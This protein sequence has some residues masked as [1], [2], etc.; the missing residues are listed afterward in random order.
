MTFRLKKLLPNPDIT[1]VTTA[2]AALQLLLPTGLPPP[3][4]F[5]IFDEILCQEQNVSSADTMQRGSDVTR[6]VRAHED[7]LVMAALVP[8]PH[9]AIP[10]I[11]LSGNA[12]TE[13]HA[14]IA[15]AAGQDAILS[16]PLS[17]EQLA[18]TVHEVLRRMDF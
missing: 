8:P 15:T 7:A 1:A 11:G 16:K 5:C 3:F 4:D 14:A 18:A 2:E 13:E 17:N 10:I 6:A 9:R 12:G